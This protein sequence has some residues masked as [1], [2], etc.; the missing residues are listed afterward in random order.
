M[1]NNCFWMLLSI[2]PPHVRT[3]FTEKI[4]TKLLNVQ[5]N[6]LRICYT[7]FDTTGAVK[8]EWTATV[9]LAFQINYSF[10]G[11]TFY[12]IQVYLITYGNFLQQNI[13]QI[14]RNLYK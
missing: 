14:V 2:Y 5:Q 4:S 7:D 10:Q 9:C 1:V 8:R 11:T 6:C 12:K 13:A 3:A